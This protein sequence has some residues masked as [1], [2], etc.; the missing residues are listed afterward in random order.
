MSNGTFTAAVL[1]TATHSPASLLPAPL[2]KGNVGVCLSGG[3]S[4]A[5]SAG[6]GQLLALETLQANGASLLSQVSVLTTVSGGGWIGIP[7]VYLPAAITDSSF[8]GIYTPPNGLTLSMLNRTPPGIGAEVTKSFSVPA[9]AITALT[10]HFKHG[11]P[12]NMVWQTIMGLTFLSPFGLFVPG[13]ND[14]PTA[15]F[16]YDAA[17]LNI[18]VTG[19]NPGLGAEPTLLIE[20]HAGQRRPYLVSLFAI[21]VDPHNPAA[22]LVPVQSTPIGTGVVGTPAAVDA[23][24]LAVGGGMVPSFAFN[25]SPAAMSGA[26]VAVQQLRQWSLTDAIGTSSA[27]FVEQIIEHFEKLKKSPIQF[28][29]EIRLHKGEVM[30]KLARLNH[31]IVDTALWLDG[32]DVTSPVPNIT[33]PNM[34]EMM[35]NM[36]A[37]EDIVPAYTY[38]SPANPPAGRPLL[39][40]HFADGGNLE[41]TGIASM[42]SYSNIT[43]IIAFGNFATQLAAGVDGTIAM[44]DSVPPLFGFQP[45]SSNGGYVPFGDDAASRDGSVYGHNQVFPQSAF[46]ELQQGLWAANGHGMS[47]GVSTFTQTLTT[48]ANDWFGV[49]AGKQVTVVWVYLQYAKPWHDAITDEFVKLAVDAEVSIAHFPHFNTLLTQLLPMQVQLLSNF[50]SWVVQ[51]PEN[52]GQ[53]TSLF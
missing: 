33:G 32:I 35:A 27:A 37:L 2:A 25:S 43:K 44:D 7:F 18:Y 1:P 29:A 5:F 22:L 34:L 31:Q 17:S 16:S 9:I 52:S 46:A 36:P 50:A 53:F 47:T 19:P 13:Q 40:T 11:V 15:L 14:A 30:E 41:N 10:L 38:W 6:L 20:Q 39:P 24:G 49:P 26:D 28:A 42:L 8:L 4:R 3:G 21:S 48:V 51:A 12:W 23:N 45:Y